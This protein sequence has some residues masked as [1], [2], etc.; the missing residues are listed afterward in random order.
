MKKLLISFIVFAVCLVTLFNFLDSDEIE[1]EQN[2]QASPATDLFIKKVKKKVVKEKQ[3]ETIKID[4]KNIPTKEEILEVLRGKDEIEKV[5]DLPD[6]KDLP[7]QPNP[8]P[9]KYQIHSV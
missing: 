4:L 1:K 5:E 8:V 3:V 2:K 7:S 9:K 6:I